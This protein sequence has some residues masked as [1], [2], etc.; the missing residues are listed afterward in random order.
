MRI[1]RCPHQARSTRATCAE[2][3]VD[4]DRT[5]CSDLPGR[6]AQCDGQSE[7]GVL[8]VV[9]VVEVDV[10]EVWLLIAASVVL[11]ALVQRDVRNREPPV[12]RAAPRC[13]TPV[14]EFLG[15]ETGEPVYRPQ[16][17]V[18][19]ATGLAGIDAP[20]SLL[21]KLRG[22]SRITVKERDPDLAVILVRVPLRRY[23]LRLQI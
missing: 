23:D 14:L 6:R 1:T 21:S 5:Y 2:S 12:A 3:V 8:T 16:I 15:V 7:P 9:C 20:P 22:A 4:G 13:A 17:G 11:V 10:H 18:P 19:D